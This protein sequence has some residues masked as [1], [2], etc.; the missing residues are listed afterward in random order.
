LEFREGPLTPELVDQE[1]LKVNKGVYVT[2]LT[3]DGGALKAGLKSGDVIVAL[4]GEKINSMGD[5]Q[6]QIAPHRP[7]EKVTVT[8]NRKGEEKDYAVTL[9]TP[10]GET[11]TVGSSEFWAYLGADL[12]K[13]S[14]KDLEKLN[15]RQW[16]AGNQNPRW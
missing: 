9:K 10:A 7:G 1:N 16:C 8:V 6:E 12:E 14:E 15:S 4:N 11:K 2:D 3:Q 5:L 13:L